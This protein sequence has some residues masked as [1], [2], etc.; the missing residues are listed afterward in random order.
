MALFLPD[1][2]ILINALR[3]DSKAHHECKDWLAGATEAG[4]QIG[5]CEVVEIALIR[6]CTLPQLL[7]PALRP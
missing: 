2:N 1:A 5:L 7:L 4:D 3:Y 6:I